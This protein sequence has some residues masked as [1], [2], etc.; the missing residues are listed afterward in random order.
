MQPHNVLHSS[1]A[2]PGAAAGP[3]RVLIVDDHPDA[4]RILGLLLESLGHQVRA[5]HNAH[6]AFTQVDHFGPEIVLC[7]IGLPGVDGYEVARQLRSSP[8]GLAMKLIALT[9]WGHD[10][11]RRRSREAGF[12]HHLVKP[13]S[14]STLRELIGIAR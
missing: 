9:G 1:P 3:R 14:S 8:R 11:D 10:E 5:A 12:D 4:A 7:D 13:V 2:S 6:E